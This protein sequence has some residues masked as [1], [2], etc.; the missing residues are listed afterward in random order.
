M[1]LGESWESFLEWSDEKG[2][3]FRG[4]NDALEEHGV[5]ALPVL[6][7]LVLLLV[8]GVAFV[9][10][11]G[12]FGPSTTKLV[13]KAVSDEGVSLEGV[14]VGVKSVDGQRFSAVTDSRGR[15]TFEGVPIGEATVS[16]S[17]AEYVFGEE[18]FQVVDLQGES[19]SLTV[20]GELLFSDSVTL[21]VELEGVK[22]A[23]VYLK[24]A[25]SSEQLDYSYALAGSASF[26]VKPN[27]QYLLEASA[28]GY[29]PASRKVE[30]GETDFGPVTLELVP[31]SES[32]Q[33]VLRVRVLDGDGINAPSVANAT[34]EFVEPATGAVK[35]SFESAE[36][37]SVP[38]ALFVKGA[39]VSVIV[40]AEGFELWEKIVELKDAT[41]NMDARLQPP[42]G[43]YAS[44][45]VRVLDEFGRLVPGPAV[46]LYSNSKQLLSETPFLGI[47][48]FNVSRNEQYSVAAFK[49]GYLPAFQDLTGFEVDVVLEKATDEN[50][51]SIRLRVIDAKGLEV[52]GALATLEWN[53]E[54]LGVTARET[55]ADGTQFFEGVPLLQEVV[56]VVSDGSHVARSEPFA[57]EAGVETEVLVQLPLLEINS[58]VIVRNYYSSQVVS[59][60]V[61]SFYPEDGPRNSCTTNAGGACFLEVTEGYSGVVVEAEGYEDLE[62]SSVLVAPGEQHV[63]ELV[64]EDAA[65]PQLIF[66]GLYSLDG[67]K[68]VSVDPYTT[69]NAKYVFTAPPEIEFSKAIAYVS[70]GEA[71]GLAGDDE[72]VIIGFSAAG[73]SVS[74][75]SE[76]EQTA[77]EEIA[78]S[79]I[80]ISVTDVEVL[81]YESILLKGGKALF[82]NEAEQEKKISIDGE[83]EAVSI[84]PGNSFEYSFQD[85]GNYALLVDGEY[86][87][88]ISV[89]AQQE[90]EERAIDENG[91]KWV[92]F[93]YGSSFEGSKELLVQ[94]RTAAP[95]TGVSLHQRSAF[96][97]SRGVLRDPVDDEADE[98]GSPATRLSASFDNDFQGSCSPEENVCVKAFFSG[99]TSSRNGFEAELGEKIQLFYE[100]FSDPGRALKLEAI[101][102]TNAL[103]FTEGGSD[104]FSTDASGHAAGSF[105]ILPQRLSENAVISITV[106]DGNQAIFGN[107]VSLRVTSEKPPALIVTPSKQS[108]IALDE[109]ELVFAVRD[110]FGLAVE[111]ASIT[112][113]S[114]DGTLASPVQATE[115]G[116]GV[117]SASLQALGAGTI[118][119]SIIA[120]GFKQ[121]KGYLAVAAPANFLEA[122]PSSIRASVTDLEGEIQSFTLTN[123]LSNDVRVTATL[124]TQ[125]KSEYTAFSILPS[126]F[127]LKGG[128]SIEGALYS[129]P[130]PSLLLVARQAATLKEDVA[131]KIRLRARVG[132]TTQT[133]EV[134]FQART[135]LF[136]P[137]L[138]ES[139]GISATSLDYAFDP[140]I[141]SRES[142]TIT[143]Q[144]NA[145]QPLLINQ[146]SSLRGVFVLPVSAV[147]QPGE[148]LDFEVTASSAA[149]LA[150]DGCMT[151]DDE[152]QGVLSLY[153]SFQ[154]IR[155]SK[156]VDLRADLS[157]AAPCLPENGYTVNLPL[158]AEMAL[159]QGYKE[160]K[161]QDGS[162]SVQPFGAEIMAAQSGQIRDGSLRVPLQTNLVLPPQWVARIPNGWQIMMP[163]EFRLY[164]SDESASQ[165]SDGSIKLNVYDG[166]F[167]FAPGSRIATLA[168]GRAII[169]PPGAPIQFTQTSCD[170]LMNL[171][172]SNAIKLVLPVDT[173]FYP[174]Y[175]SSFNDEQ[176]SSCPASQTHYDQGLSD[177]LRAGK[178]LSSPDGLHIAFTD[179]A[180]P[181]K[182]QLGFTS[183]VF[184]P[185]GIGILVP[186]Q[187][188]SSS[189]DVVEVTFPMPLQFSFAKSGASQ[190]VK[191]GSNY[192]VK[193]SADAAIRFSFNPDPQTSGSKQIISV[194][195]STT[196]TFLSGARAMEVI[197]PGA[198]SPCTQEFEADED[199]LISLPYSAKTRQDGTKVIATM[200]GC[201]ADSRVQVLSAEKPGIVLYES[202]ASLKV[203]IPRGKLEDD[204]GYQ[205]ISAP[206]NARLSFTT[207]AKASKDLK[208]VTIQ[209]PEQAIIPVP[210]GAEVKGEKLKLGALT[211]LELQYAQGKSFKL[212]TTDELEFQPSDTNEFKHDASQIIL[213]PLSKISFVPYCDKAAKTT[214]IKANAGYLDV[215]LLEGAR[216][217]KDDGSPIQEG[218][219][220]ELELSNNDLKGVPPF[221]LCLINKATKD[222]E[223]LGVEVRPTSA[224]QFNA[225][226]E[227]TLI[228]LEFGKNG[229]LFFD[230]ATDGWTTQISTTPEENACNRFTVV[231]VVPSSLTTGVPPCIQKDFDGTVELVFK[232]R[233]EG[234]DGERVVPI[235]LK[236]DADENACKS[237]EGAASWLEGVKVNHDL[238]DALKGRSN[239]VQLSF[240]GAGE[241][242]YRYVSVNSFSDQLL[243][244]YPKSSDLQCRRVTSL[245]ET[246]SLMPGQELAPGEGL[247]LKCWPAKAPEEGKQYS[248]THVIKF[249]SEPNPS[250]DD[251]PL[252]T[253]N[254]NVV[255]Y[256]SD[257]DLYSSTPLGAVLCQEDEE[258]C[259]P[260][261]VEAAL[262]E[263]AE[264]VPPEEAETA[265]LTTA[266]LDGSDE[267]GG[268]S[269]QSLQKCET[270]YCTTMQFVEAFRSA[271]YGSVELLKQRLAEEYMLD[272]YCSLELD[273]PLSGTL[274]LQATN[275]RADLDVSTQVQNVFQ[276]FKS[277]PE[278]LARAEFSGASELDGCGVYKLE[279]QPVLD[280]AKRYSGED[281]DSWEGVK[282]NT[283]IQYSIVK[284]AGCEETLANAALLMPPDATV[285]FVG[286]K[287]TPGLFEFDAYENIPIVFGG[288]DPEADPV[289]SANAVNAFKA[290]Y[291]IGEVREGQSSRYDDGEKCWNNLAGEFYGATGTLVGGCLAGIALS[292]IGVGANVARAF[293]TSLFEVGTCMAGNTIRGS[294]DGKWCHTW[295]ICTH[296]AI[297]GIV[298]AVFHSIFPL[299]GA[300]KP[301]SGFSLEAVKSAF[302]AKNLKSFGI[303]LG[304]Q[305]AAQGG[306][307]FFEDER[308]AAA[309]GYALSSYSSYLV[310][311][312]I[313]GPGSSAPLAVTSK[314]GITAA[315]LSSKA[316]GE[317]DDVLTRIEKTLVDEDGSIV[318]TRADMDGFAGELDKIAS[319]SRFA[320]DDLFNI[321]NSLRGMED[322]LKRSNPDFFRLKWGDLKTEVK[323]S[324]EGVTAAG[325][326]AAVGREVTGLGD[327]AVR[328]SNLQLESQL[329]DLFKQQRAVNEVAKLIEGIK[330]IDS[331]K[332]TNLDLRMLVSKVNAHA[333]ELPVELADSI[334]KLNLKSLAAASDTQTIQRGLVDIIGDFEVKSNGLTDEMKKLLRGAP[335]E[336]TQRI[337]AEAGGSASKRATKEAGQEAVEETTSGAF[338]K[339][340]KLGTTF[341]S[342]IG[343]S[344]VVSLVT[345]VESRP[346]Q[347]VAYE[348]LPSYVFSYSEESLSRFCAEQ[349]TEADCENELD[350][351][352]A[353]GDGQTCIRMARNPQTGREQGYLLLL[354]HNDEEVKAESLGKVYETVF[355]PDYAVL[356]SGELSQKL[357]GNYRAG[358][359]EELA[360]VRELTTNYAEEVVEIREKTDSI[361][362]ELKEEEEGAEE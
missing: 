197:D 136:I 342:A 296:E 262:P 289:S 196:V 267:E 106:L 124:F 361:Q 329:D 70:I 204:S 210:K 155:S 28:P 63:F 295:N 246:S 95:S 75:G 145:P 310:R 190:P 270:H 326:G 308:I 142:Q 249:Y 269:R 337:S 323:N 243:Y 180:K 311:N 208:A 135:N 317:V 205:T 248:F 327:D 166:S 12:L 119:Y 83:F 220:I 300:V 306:T 273:R 288:Y 39:N 211:N 132:S 362:E 11:P 207:C 152:P 55:L 258:A 51:G 79:S 149:L 283:E 14:E 57:V 334:R 303:M 47:A 336:V 146:D 90:Q 214:T 13:I 121:K 53:N 224:V 292:F 46:T 29:S 236:V 110:E 64:S 76:Y 346:V 143:V 256:H 184:V 229:N 194:P 330:E 104:S 60:A 96:H 131:G 245:G 19:I 319:D 287:E 165:Q 139:W 325:A 188:A 222:I 352:E 206:A 301:A 178:V 100:V 8:A 115:T 153:A 82:K 54:P 348:D 158:D 32:N 322:E 298:D 358:F 343:P 260:I 15:A 163:L 105:E 10:L 1:V 125:G 201:D 5:P 169:A 291:G 223:L 102:V 276:E 219:A 226:V 339:L 275:F 233:Y 112:L 332:L 227:R 218:N 118:S 89:A 170:Q 34:I 274:Y 316:V 231:P 349:T 321:R 239:S 73:A 186:P 304:F 284:M 209:L 356:T 168:G 281:E 221:K 338:S 87:A 199:V 320:G 217:E 156:P 247:L 52:S 238:A 92:E 347:V 148:S 257:S 198:A 360:G 98:T 41:K 4:F 297:I 85:E 162:I 26:K 27:R 147:I 351:S 144:N 62:V 22:E 213:P 341:L 120:T 172:P 65:G 154:G 37:G 45:K 126:S 293:C 354:V 312:H 230:E 173:T 59:G 111:G 254:I 91:L 77:V 94:V 97:T 266:S 122:T 78:S 129:Y 151:Q 50:S 25:D 203:E 33:A 359:E 285:A 279:I 58:N 114:Y 294:I 192:V 81:P 315:T 250:Q 66:R 335:D 174:L 183:K 67:D 7:V 272:Y 309:S 299:G 20:S 195:P 265:P 318:L 56:A 107:E 353:C 103:S 344:V 140:A 280:C 242:H 215:R 313:K 61:V 123:R 286:K 16:V 38:D 282:A 157:S 331:S 271:L 3:P 261:I 216:A 113:S 212:S 9:A 167:T 36:D 160:K 23:S 333:E 108:I 185:A 200:T 69:Y 150:E 74:Y 21:Y 176:G 42:L 251:E 263:E 234:E 244:V 357:G 187:I 202:P 259:K 24:D 241:N 128:E 305:T 161:N 93:T 225:E 177:F 164:L 80:T 328:L 18:A 17:S 99:L 324:L 314:A 130:D 138:D 253:K 235:H 40:S 72:S 268:A 182:D 35:Y 30:V 109:E 240:K 141:E 290:L 264:A 48:E 355:N 175:G 302:G 43:S 171:M 137:S 181:E 191:D 71:T 228:P 127:V 159:P 193:V 44:L 237:V 277:S 133:I 116:E 86:A 68:V 49:P 101:P 307:G 278:G 252:Y 6:L 88:S 134:P 255:V 31:L 232:T 189:E 117:Y 350:L 84:S 345:T 179:D 2:L 340:R